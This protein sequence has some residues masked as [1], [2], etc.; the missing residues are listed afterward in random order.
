M[1]YEYSTNVHEIRGRAFAGIGSL[2]FRQ[3]FIKMAVFAGNI[4][5][6]RILI[7]RFFGIFAI[8]SFVVQFFST[9]GNVGIGAALIQKKDEL[10]DLLLS[11]IFWFQQILVLSVIIIVALIAPYVVKL[12]PTLP[13]GSMW[14]IRAMAL[15]FFFSSLK[16]IPAI[17]MERSLNYKK[18]VWIDITETLVF[19][20]VVIVCALAGLNVWSFI[21]AAISRGL[22]GAIITF[23]LLPWKPSFSFSFISIKPLLK[24]GI[25]YQANG[26]LSLIKD[27]VTPIFIGSYVGAAAVGYVNWAKNLALAPM[28]LSESYNK[29]SF[30]AFSRIQDDKPLLTRAIEKSMRTLTTIM[31]PITTLAIALGPEI[32]H[33]V[34]TDK[35]MP[36]IWAFYFFCTAPLTIGI[37]LPMYSAILSLGKSSV[38]LKMS[39]LLLFLEWGLGVPFI[40]LFGFTGV[41][42]NQPILAIIFFFI[43]NNVLKNNNITVSVTKNVIFQL[44]LAVSSALIIKLIAAAI[45]VNL[46]IL[47]ILML[48]GFFMY[49]LGVFIFKKSILL[50]FEDFIKTAII[51]NKTKTSPVKI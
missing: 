10:S 13:A 1:D 26:V 38:I 28:M 43:Y 44:L 39:T 33:I 36:G 25:P 23:I 24:F 47:L 9:F 42:V 51:H 22:A 49:I 32:T 7:P 21:I 19:Q 48:A 3:L 16:T 41:A 14:L 35:W 6:A 37:V 46:I 34:F 45:H 11:T 17:L 18:I 30:T 31:F 15:S 8:V 40:L 50:E 29:V 27:S 4:V 2:L 20:T 5:L 12:Y